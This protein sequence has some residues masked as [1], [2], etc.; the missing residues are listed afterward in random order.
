[1]IDKDNFP[2]NILEN[3]S[4]K[5]IESK[6]QAEKDLK[7][8]LSNDV[9][10]QNNN[11]KTLLSL[12]KTKFEISTTPN[13]KKGVFICLTFITANINSDK[14]ANQ[15]IIISI[16][17]TIQKFFNEK[18]PKIIAV[19]A[20]S[21][22]SILKF[23]SKI[24]SENFSKFFKCL[25]I[26]S[27]NPDSDVKI[28]SKNIDFLMKEIINYYFEENIFNDDFSEKFIKEIYYQ[29]NLSQNYSVKILIVGWLT[30]VNSL[31]E[32]NLVNVLYEFVPKLFDILENSTNYSIFK[33]KKEKKNEK[34]SKYVASTYDNNDKIEDTQINN[35]QFK[36]SFKNKNTIK[37]KRDYND[38]DN[39]NR[40]NLVKK[41]KLNEEEIKNS[42]LSPLIGNTENTKIL[43]LPGESPEI[44]NE[45]IKATEALLL[46][47]FKDMENKLDYLSI[48]EEKKILSMLIS[49]GNNS[50]YYAVKVIV[51]EWL[52]IFLENY[53]NTL[54]LISKDFY[55]E[56]IEKIEDY[57][58]GDNM[59][60]K[61]ILNNF[62]ENSDAIQIQ[63][64]LISQSIYPYN[65]ET[66]INSGFFKKIDGDNKA[67]EIF[68]KNSLLVIE[69]ANIS[70]FY[71]QYKDKDKKNT[72]ELRNSKFS[73]K[74]DNKLSYLSNKDLTKDKN[75]SARNSFDYGYNSA[76]KQLRKMSKSI[77][78]FHSN[79]NF[80][81]N[82]FNKEAIFE[83]LLSQEDRKIQ[84]EFLPS[85]L[86]IVIKNI[87]NSNENIKKITSMCNK[88]LIKI[89]DMYWNFNKDNIQL[90]EKV[91]QSNFL[92]GNDSTLEVVIFWMNKI[93]KK[94]SHESKDKSDSIETFIKNLVSLLDYSNETIFQSLLTNICE[95][96]EINRDFTDIILTLILK[97][98]NENQSL[99]DTRGVNILKQLSKHLNIETLLETF[100]QVLY[101]IYYQDD[102]FV[103]KMISLMDIIMLSTSENWKVKINL[104]KNRTFF[105]R[106]FKTW[107][108]NPISSL[109]LS[110]FGEFYELSHA[111]VL[112]L[113][114]QKLK[115]E[116]YLQLAYIVQ[117]IEGEAFLNL[118]LHLLEPLKYHHLVKSM[119]GILLIIPQGKAYASLCKR[120]KIVENI[121]KI[122]E[123]D[124]NQKK[125]ELENEDI[126]EYLKIYESLQKNKNN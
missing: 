34:S 2:I 81:L 77:N 36:E 68:Q 51:F 112:E 53:K 7:L 101:E 15:D 27:S 108:K 86:D 109:L 28:I 22:Y 76:V 83:Y 43:L 12:L 62:Y 90:F 42:K 65:Q 38:D 92:T 6:K 91:L 120:M 89:I 58:G 122:T 82:H 100:S 48:E 13:I 110:L 55:K 98:F 70:S 23:H 20:E 41:E 61:L 24:L 114:L 9:Q 30:F 11:Y 87:C 111:L 35:D 117:L 123:F 79:F 67:S 31:P 116:N 66:N 80:N 32:I 78:N 125:L 1:M 59:N 4:N 97:K 57:N 60:T 75:E 96:G 49:Y 8:Y 54:T 39:I 25:I 10:I 107:C 18:D 121:L 106:L 14:E 115:P 71:Y 103:G 104:I 85:I 45:T 26:L 69:T 94:I 50:N 44:I 33:S 52:Y 73:L 95:I 93:F 124:K 46:E 99:I 113:G 84:I 102:K 17:D 88:N 47:L 3:F 63:N 21:L 119:Y 105:K 40:K 37:N 64:N 19:A 56:H 16:V 118:R 5:N 74:H 29:L 126:T 72:T